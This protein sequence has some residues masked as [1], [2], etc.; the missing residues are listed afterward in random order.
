MVGRFLCAKKK[1]QEGRAE[2]EWSQSKRRTNLDTYAW[3]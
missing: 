2:D 3:V 1:K